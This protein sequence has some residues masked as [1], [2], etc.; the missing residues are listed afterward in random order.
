MLVELWESSHAGFL[1]VLSVSLWCCESRT[2]KGEC[3][4]I[5]LVL[6]QNFRC[7]SF[8]IWI[9]HTCKTGLEVPQEKFSFEGFALIWVGSI[10]KISCGLLFEFL[11]F[12]LHQE[13]K[14]LKFWA[15]G[16]RWNKIEN[17]HV[18]NFTHLQRFSLQIF[19]KFCIKVWSGSDVIQ[20]DSSASH[21]LPSGWITLHISKMHYQ[22]TQAEEH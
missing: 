5:M 17:T 16:R 7:L 22:H 14:F 19:A 21:C 6:A 18:D 20:S 3:K 9:P 2:V 13:I 1:S 10:Q 15:S 11:Q 8:V 12:F 4:S